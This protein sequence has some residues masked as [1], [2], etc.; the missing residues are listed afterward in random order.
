MSV[1]IFLVLENADITDCVTKSA[2]GYGQQLMQ[3]FLDVSRGLRS[4]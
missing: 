1:S 2:P 3:A 4:I